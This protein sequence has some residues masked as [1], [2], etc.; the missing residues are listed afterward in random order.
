MATIPRIAESSVEL[1]EYAVAGNGID[2]VPES[3]SC[4]AELVVARLKVVCVG[5]GVGRSSGG[6]RESLAVLLALRC[7]L[8]LVVISDDVGAGSSLW[9]TMRHN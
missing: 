2:F 8:S 1:G 5:A 6:G 3:V 4:C 7:S 9:W